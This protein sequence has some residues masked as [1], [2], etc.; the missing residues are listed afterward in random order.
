LASVLLIVVPLLL[1]GLPCHLLNY[2]LAGENGG[3]AN[4]LRWLVIALLCLFVVAVAYYLAFHMWPE[5]LFDDAATINQAPFTCD[6]M[7]H[8]TSGVSPLAPLA[9]LC[10]AIAFVARGGSERAVMCARWSNLDFLK[11][12]P[13]RKLRSSLNNVCEGDGKSFVLRALKWSPLAILVGVALAHYAFHSVDMLD[14]LSYTWIVFGLLVIMATAM[15]L[16]TARF[17]DL[18]YWLLHTLKLLAA[19]P[20]AD[21]LRCERLPAKLCKEVEQIFLGAEPALLDMASRALVLRSLVAADPK[22]APHDLVTQI[23]DIATKS[24]A[25][26]DLDRVSRLW[27]NLGAAYEGNSDLVRQ[28]KEK[29]AG[30]AEEDKTAQASPARRIS[31]SVA[32]DIPPIECVWSAPSEGGQVVALEDLVAMLVVMQIRTALCCLRKLLYSTLIISMGIA[33]AV[34]SYPFLPRT[35]LALAALSVPLVALSLPLLRLFIELSKDRILSQIS[36]SKPQIVEFSG[37]NILNVTLLVAVPLISGLIYQFPALAKP[38]YSLR[39]VISH[40]QK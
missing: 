37:S 20:L 36:G 40:V 13:A 6:R 26:R 12:E 33:F 14:S 5:T 35:P 22:L 11:I 9:L 7:Y 3:L 31:V 25:D 8:I 39:D 4:W 16:T 27:W 15:I 28:L 38:L 34:E 19:E 2:P 21:A 1:V 30:S 17:Y 32:S 10:L 18:A 24:L 23:S 29:W